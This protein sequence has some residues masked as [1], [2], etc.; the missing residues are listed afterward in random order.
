MKMKVIEFFVEI[1]DDSIAVA[2]LL[3]NDSQ[4]NM[5]T[6]IY[7]LKECRNWCVK[8][9]ML[10]VQQYQFQRIYQDNGTSVLDVQ[11]AATKEKDLRKI[12]N[13]TYVN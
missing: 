11:F 7:A 13:V 12:R 3:N 1:L 9:S 10:L 6:V 8:N 4:M 2:L 5:M